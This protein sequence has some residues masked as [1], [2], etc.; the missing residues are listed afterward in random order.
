[1]NL[2]HPMSIPHTYS[3]YEH[4]LLIPITGV[5][6]HDVDSAYHVFIHAD[7]RGPSESYKGSLLLTITRGK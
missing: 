6:L 4:G 3:S 1:M 5:E 2:P 7:A